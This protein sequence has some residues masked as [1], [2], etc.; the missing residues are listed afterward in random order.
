MQLSEDFLG[1]LAG[2]VFKDIFKR[3]QPFLDFDVFNI[4]TERIDAFWTHIVRHCIMVF[5]YALMEERPSTGASIFPLG[6]FLI[7]IYMIDIVML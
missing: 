7:V 1:L 6:V 3:I 5:S 2:A 4:G